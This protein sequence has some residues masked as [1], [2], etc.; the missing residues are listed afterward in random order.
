MH[1]LPGYLVLG[2]ERNCSELLH[3]INKLAYIPA[4]ADVPV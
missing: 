2:S 1:Q 3:L 4:L